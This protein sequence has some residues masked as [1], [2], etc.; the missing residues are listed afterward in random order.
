MKAGLVHRLAF[1][2]VIRCVMTFGV[3]SAVAQFAGPAVGTPSTQA[4]GPNAALQ[5]QYVDVKIMPGDVISIATYGA[6]ELTTGSG[7]VGGVKVGAQGEIVLPY[8]GVVKVAGMTPS[9]TALYLERELKDKGILVDPQVTVSLVDSPTRVITVLGE[10]Q[11]PAP[12]PAFGQLRLLDVISACGGFTPLASHT[13]TVRRVGEPNPITIILG[14]DPKTTDETNIPLMAGDTVIVPKVGNVFVIGQVKTPSAIPLSSNAPI[15]V[16]RAIAMSGG[17]NFGAALSKVVII[18]KTPDDQHVEIQ[19]DLKKVMHGKE[20]DV[21]L[22]S[23]DV[24]LV[25]SNGFKAG[26]AVGGAGVSA[27][28]TS[29]LIY[30]IP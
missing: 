14:T 18:R 1:T 3:S 7:S 27:G 4:P 25:P 9:E 17:L 22:A 21:A 16:M 26:M 15:T 12:I 2:A 6:P 11:K 30:R 13:I 20:R 29:G 8:I 5:A 19:M 23:D 10:V 24:L 28:I